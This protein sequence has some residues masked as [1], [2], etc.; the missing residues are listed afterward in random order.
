LY[1][2]NHYDLLTSSPEGED[3]ERIRKKETSRSLHLKEQRTPPY[4]QL[5]DGVDHGSLK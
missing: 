3:D 4:S 1:I 2:F 5:R